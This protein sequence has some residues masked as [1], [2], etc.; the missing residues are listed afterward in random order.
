MRIYRSTNVFKDERGLIINIS[1]DEDI[2]DVLYITGKPG[3][4]RGSHYHQKDSHYCYIL[5]GIIDYQYKDPETN[6]T[7]TERLSKGDIVYSAP[8]EHH[9]FVFQTHGAFIAMATQSR[10][11]NDY[12]N[13]TIRIE[14]EK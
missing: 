10:V 7:V 12:E 3:A 14:F 13:D 6:E 1:P 5:K 9:R 11:Q 8:M 4:V 2:K